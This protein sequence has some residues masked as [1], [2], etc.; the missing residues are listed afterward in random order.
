MSG[1]ATFTIETLFYESMP[2]FILLPPQEQKFIDNRNLRA[3]MAVQC[4]AGIALALTFAF[5]HLVFRRGET[6]FLDIACIDQ[7]DA[8]TKAAGINSL[9]ALLD[10]SRRMVVLLDEHNM[11]RMWCVFEVAAFANVAEYGKWKR[12]RARKEEE[13]LKKERGGTLEATPR[14]LYNGLDERRWRM[15]VC[16]TWGR[17][18]AS[19]CK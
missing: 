2:S 3:S 17:F 16:A 1:M 5:G 7:C 13:R 4:C 6:A 18:F 8:T 10:R 14:G 15:C 9:G 12:A 11:K 19:L